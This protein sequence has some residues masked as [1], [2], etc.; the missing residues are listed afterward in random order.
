[1]KKL[2]KILII[3]V[4]SVFLVAGTAMALPILELSDGTNTVTIYD[5]DYVS[6]GGDKWPGPGA[7]SYLG[8]LGNFE[9]NVTTGVTKPFIGETYYP[10]LDLNSINVSS[11][12][13]GGEL[14]IKWTETDFTLPD[15]LSGFN[16]FIGGTTTGIVTLKTYLDEANAAFG[17]TTLLSS[18]GP[19]SSMAFSDEYQMAIN[20]ADPFSLTIVATITHSAGDLT[21]F[22]AGISPAP[23]PATML[24]LG[25]GLI[26][27]ARFGRKKLLFRK[28]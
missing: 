27:L 11:S 2:S 10:M 20:L 22:D 24:L 26:G 21:S 7:V 14:I 23:E 3:T 9:L 19:F 15:T 5:D 16:S 12:S 13:E 8:T 25:S 17:M 1:M 6:G 4:L 28:G 18:L